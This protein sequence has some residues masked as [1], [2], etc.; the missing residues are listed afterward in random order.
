MVD[1]RFDTDG[2]GQDEASRLRHRLEG[3]LPNVLRRTA[4]A[5]FGAAQATED[6]VRG[7]VGEMK[8]PKEAVA[9][10]VE[11]ADNTKKEVVRVAAREFREFL[12]SSNLGEEIARILT[13]LSF[14]VR[15]EVRFI[16]NDQKLKPNV[17]SQVRVKKSGK[18]GESVAAAAA[19]EVAEQVA[20]HVA[21]HVARAHLGIIEGFDDLLRAG[22]TEVAERILRRRRGEDGEPAD[23][24]EDA[25]P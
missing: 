7:V 23:D 13:T 21:E 20:E 17:R 19:D 10:L 9:Y 4:S 15:T 6:I 22:A 25:E 12:E 16:P 2:D 11:L 14:E 1:D 24:E 5:G 8:L 18:G 3:L